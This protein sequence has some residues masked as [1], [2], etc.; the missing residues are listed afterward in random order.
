M[1][2]DAQRD[3][4]ILKSNFQDAFISLHVWY[5]QNGMLLNTEKTKIMI[6]TTRQKRRHIDESVL[7]LSYNYV[8]L[9]IITGDKIPGIN[10]DANLTWIDHA[11]L[12]VKRYPPMFGCCLRYVLI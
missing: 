1:L 8:D 11:I 12:S 7:S 4:H 9:E 5:K 6:I 2:I 3:L 10:I